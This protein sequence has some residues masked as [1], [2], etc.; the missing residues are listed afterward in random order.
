MKRRREWEQLIE[1]GLLQ[2][3]AHRVAAMHEIEVPPIALERPCQ[4]QNVANATKVDEVEPF[5]IDRHRL[6]TVAKALFD[7]RREVGSSGRLHP[8]LGPS[9]QALPLLL[10]LDLHAVIQCRTVV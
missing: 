1:P 3:L 10:K 2:S 6:D 8:P 9:D 7:S 5:Q 4:S